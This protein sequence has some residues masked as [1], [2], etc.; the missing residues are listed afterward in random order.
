MSRFAVLIGNSRFPIDSGLQ[1]LRCPENDVDGMARILS[2]K[3]YGYFDQTTNLKNRTTADVKREMAKVFGRANSDDLVLVYYSGHGKQDMEG[4]L[5]LATS[6]TFASSSIDL[7]STALPVADLRNFIRH[8]RTNKVILIL[9]CCYSGAIGNT[10]LRGADPNVVLAN[11]DEGR[12]TYILTG[13]TSLQTAQEK[14]EDKYGLLT[15]HIIAGIETG[16][17]D[18]DSDGLISMDDLYC[19]VYDMVRK[20]GPQTPMQWALNVQGKELAIA[21]AAKT[22]RPL[23]QVQNEATSSHRI[24][25]EK[26]EPPGGVVRLNSPF[27]V[28][29]T[30]DDLFFAAIRRRDQIVLIK[31]AR[32]IGKTS[33]LSRGLQQGRSTGA[34]VAVTDFQVFGYEDLDTLESFYIALANL[35]SDKLNLNMVLKDVWNPNRGATIN[36]GRYMKKLLAVLNQPLVWG[37]DEVDGLFTRDY[38]SEVFGLFRS[39]YNETQLDPES[40]WKNLT[41]VVSYATEAS[42]FIKDL[43]QS[44]FN[45]GTRLVLQDFFPE[46]VADLN[47]RHNQPLVNMSEL[48][49]FYALLGGHPFLV[50]CG[51]YSLVSENLRFSE[52]QKIADREDGPFG[53]HL[54]RFIELIDRDPTMKD[55]VKDI[56]NGLGCSTE[57][58]YR[59]RSAGL[60]AGE[61]A[62]EVRPRCEL[63]RKYLER[64]LVKPRPGQS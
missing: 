25:L 46:Q 42:L 37:L 7:M 63:Y 5:Y 27:Y 48:E 36:F 3:D 35:L 23:S 12:G 9:D 40:P 34:R 6:D 30:A 57:S 49:G 21:R 33:L 52:F 38:G 16:S 60:M 1:D 43:N 47:D 51:F 58:F 53:E 45:V 50:R 39:W 22:Q 4:Q 20:D 61:S 26:L 18:K 10:V 32:Q 62:H 54:H 56:L 13:S 15:K 17:A 8:S 2:D 41:M 19:Y 29:R 24:E 55:Q 64:H 11:M 44:P 14:E 28:K 31:G 59:L